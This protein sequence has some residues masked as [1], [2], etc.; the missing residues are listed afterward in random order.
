[1]LVIKMENSCTC[2]KIKH[3]TDE[4]KKYLKNRL[5]TIEG[6]IRGISQM[7]DDERYCNDILIQISAV[8]KSL[9]SLGNEVLKVHLTT[10]VVDNI[11]DNNL[12]IIDEVMSLIK[13]LD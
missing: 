10:C 11:K 7:I 12:E 9:K 5:K 13:K 2:Q 4:E 6:Q 1:M 3:R 8:N